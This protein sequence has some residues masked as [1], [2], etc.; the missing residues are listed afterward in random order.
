MIH[1]L[2]ATPLVYLFLFILV[3]ILAIIYGK[4]RAAIRLITGFA[5]KLFRLPRNP[6]KVQANGAMIEMTSYPPVPSS[7]TIFRAD[8][9]GSLEQSNGTR[10]FAEVMREIK[11]SDGQSLSNRALTTSDI[12]RLTCN[13][14]T[15]SECWGCRNQICK[16]CASV[17]C[18]PSCSNMMSRT[19]RLYMK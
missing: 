10:H 2:F 17:C 14:D 3:L 15:K 18:H 1:S 9:L 19:A 6:A 7:D 12:R 4:C 11:L 16:V 13:P 5:R 8:S